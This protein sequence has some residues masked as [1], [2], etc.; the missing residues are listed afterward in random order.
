MALS[1]PPDEPSA[2]LMS[3][4]LAPTMGALVY[5]LACGLRPGRLVLQKYGIGVPEFKKLLALPA[6]VGMLRQAKRD[7]AS[8]ANTPDRVRIKSQIMTELGLEQM[9]G[10]MRDGRRPSAAR[11]S[12]FNAIKGLT[13]MDKPEEATPMQRF[14]LKIVLPPAQ[15]G[16]VTI[17]GTSATPHVR[18]E[19]SDSPDKT[20]VA[21]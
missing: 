7:F 12:A 21:A 17:E 6:F 4:P 13:G 5:E 14:S 2:P 20:G 3:G 1:L 11:V 8:L 10:I 15:G 18:Q 16:P 19:L 9:W